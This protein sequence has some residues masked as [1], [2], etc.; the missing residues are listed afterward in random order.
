MIGIVT[1]FEIGK[2]RNGTKDVLLLQVRITEPD[3]IQ[4][5]EY[6]SA[7]GDDSVPPIGSRVTIL[8]AGSAWKIAIASQDSITPVMGE[9]E[10][11]IYSSKDGAIEAFINWL[12]T[13]I[14]E[15]NGNSDFA[16]R[17]NALDAQITILNSKYDV[18][19]H[20][21]PVSGSTGVPSN[22]PLNID[23]SGAK[24]DEV[25]II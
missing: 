25:K 3:D 21:D 15:L 10:R 16:V 19:T 18:H 14:L 17:F 24:V 7:A 5:V 11:K 20:L 13:G 12:S 8:Q 1:G 9:G 4:T 6:M 23:I 22:V 2:N